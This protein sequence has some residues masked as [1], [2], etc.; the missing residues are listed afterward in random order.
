MWLNKN[1]LLAGS[2]SDPS[3][4]RLSPPLTDSTCPPVAL[5]PIPAVRASSPRPAG[6]WGSKARESGRPRRRLKVPLWRCGYGVRCGV[7]LWRPLSARY[8]LSASSFLALLASWLRLHWAETERNTE[9]RSRIERRRRRR[10]RVRPRRGKKPPTASE[11]GGRRGDGG[12]RN[13]SWRFSISAGCMS[14]PRKK[15]RTKEGK[16]GREARKGSGAID[17]GWLSTGHH[18]CRRCCPCLMFQGSV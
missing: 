8:P 4:P 2:R 13:A 7:R 17:S 18:R 3:R 14:A 5:L 11:H 1:V 16:E 15:E 10:G 6:G 9:L 12:G